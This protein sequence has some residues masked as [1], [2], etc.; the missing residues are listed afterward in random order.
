MM[1]RFSARGRLRAT[2]RHA[3]PSDRE[4]RLVRHLL[5]SLATICLAAVTFA[6][7]PS[8]SGALTPGRNGRIAFFRVDSHGSALSYTMNP[9]GTNVQV[10]YSAA[11]NEHPHWSPDGTQVVLECDSCGG[12]LIVDVDT[13]ISRILPS[14]DP[15][16]QL[17][18]GIWSPDG[19]RLAC[20][21]FNDDST[22]DGVYTIRSSD[23]GGL[24]RVTNFAGI[25]GDYSPDGRRLSFVGLDATGQ[26]R[27]FV[28]GINGAGL[29]PVTPA[30]MALNDEL[31]GS[32]S[33]NGDQILFAAR[34][35]AVSRKAIWVV[36]AD[37]SGVREL[38]IVN[39]GGEISAA[40]SIACDDP[41]WSPDGSQIA[42]SRYS[43]MTHIK[44]IYT[45][46]PDGTGLMRLTFNG[47]RDFGPDWGTHPL[48]S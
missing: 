47:A 35:D 17:G 40:T 11:D 32:W 12:T 4:R 38:P 19:K 34:P 9:D 23:G 46:R 5:C 33:P 39:C 3:H 37:G 10:L 31:G 44:D 15:T 2:S 48:T 14:P 6:A 13:G 26:L 41:V 24:R 8:P 25:P 18:C 42:F 1:D 16:L 21:S 20:A 36:N 27:I 29:T 28:I 30:G 7:V 22:R 43:A 45:V